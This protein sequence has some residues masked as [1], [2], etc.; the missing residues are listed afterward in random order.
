[1]ERIEQ[2]RSLDDDSIHPLSRTRHWT[3]GEKTSRAVLY[4]HGYTDSI[5]QFSQLGEMFYKRGF[6]VFAPRLPYH[7]Y[8]DRLNHEH[9]RLTAPEMLEWANAATDI[10]R[11]LGDCVTV[12]GLSLGGVLATWVAEQRG[13]VDRVLIIAPAFGTSMIPRSLTTPAASIAKR[14]PNR[15]IWW[16][17][18]VREQAGFEYTYPRFSTH[19][20]AQAFLL[21]GQLLEQARAQPPAARSVWMITNANDFVV[22]NAICG[23]FVKAWHSHA[24]NQAHTYQYPRP[25]GIPHDIM[26]PADPGVKPEVVYPPLINIVEQDAVNPQ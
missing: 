11:G 14:L 2:L 17:P 3:H 8:K 23:E 25:L 7:G 26:D 18:R 5:Q 20:L 10:A 12:M 22:S 24:T 4:L 13:D 21:G 9:C 15:F 19:T 6:N 16:D 1:L